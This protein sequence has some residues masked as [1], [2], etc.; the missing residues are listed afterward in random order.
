MADLVIYGSP[1]SPFVRKVAA[2]CIEKGVDFEVDAVDVFNPPE[3]FVEISPA[4]RIPVMR[5]RS[6]A[7]EGTHGTIADSSAICG[8]IEKKHP[9]PALYPADPYDHGRALW[10]EEYSDSLLAMNG[11][12]GIFRPVFFSLLQGKEPDVDTA[13]TTWSDKVRPIFDYLDAQLKGR[14]YLA[15]DA[16]SIADISV[17][18]CMMQIALVADMKL[19]DWSD[20]AAH[21]ERMTARDSIAGPYE[22]AER[23]VRKSLPE[24]ISLTG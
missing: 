3:W 21:Y 17:T 24:P 18:T 16:L 23:F 6:V 19:D 14:D 1:V 15:G 5:D 7:E 8:Y 4:R 2:L 22:K 12:G 9:E 13:R 10:Y 11:G 20:L